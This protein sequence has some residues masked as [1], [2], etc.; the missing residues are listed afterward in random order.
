VA[1][2]YLKVLSQNSTRQ[3]EENHENLR[4]VGNLI[5]IWISTSWTQV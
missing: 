2:I 4:I 1:V 3:A 5:K